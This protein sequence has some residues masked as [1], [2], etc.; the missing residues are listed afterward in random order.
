MTLMESLLKL[1]RVDASVRGLRSRL[2]SSERYLAQQER[3][4]ATID[5][6]IG[7]L[8][9]R[10]RHLQVKIS[11][12]E[13]EATQLDEKI[14][15][16]RGDLNNAANAKQYQAVLTEVETVKARRREIDDQTLA[17]MEAIETVRTQLA[18]QKGE[19]EERVKVRDIALARRDERASEVGDRLHELEQERT[20]AA[21]DVPGE[22]LGVFEHVADLH[23]GEAMATI[24]EISRRH[25]EYACGECNMHLPF[26]VVSTLVG[27]VSHVVQCPSCRRILYVQDE[28]KGALVGK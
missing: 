8:S 5:E 19:R 14:E 28:V 17:E 18:E 21:A 16:F 2:D 27:N 13:N 9:T 22:A 12:L 3:E 4:L 7:E 25:R 15:K 1:H 24:E 23:E 20:E 6:R 10:E 11:T 26:E